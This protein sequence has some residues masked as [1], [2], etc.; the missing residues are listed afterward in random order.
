[1]MED[2]VKSHGD[3]FSDVVENVKLRESIKHVLPYVG[4][5]IQNDPTDMEALHCA[6]V[7]ASLDINTADCIGNLIS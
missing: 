1:M 3:R 5:L 6:K 4:D 7:L 2:V